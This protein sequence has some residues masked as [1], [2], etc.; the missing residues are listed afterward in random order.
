MNI[1][2]WFYQLNLAYEEKGMQ[3]S[4]EKKAFLLSD[5]PDTTT[6]AQKQMIG[7]FLD[8][9]TQFFYNKASHG[10]VF[11]KLS[12]IKERFGNS[13]EENYG[14]SSGPFV[15]FAKTY[16]TYKLEV[17]DLYPNFLTLVL[18][19]ILKEIEMDIASVFSQLL[20]LLKFLLVKGKKCKENYYRS[21]HQI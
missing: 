17:G 21:L 7:E 16:W 4:P 19:K 2:Q 11:G 15:D 3:I 12:R 5:F 18:S 1:D 9:M 10:E 20:D 8:V 13:I 6:Y 14:I